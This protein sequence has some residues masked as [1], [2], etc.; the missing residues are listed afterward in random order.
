M[1]FN[2]LRGDHKLQ[3]HEKYVVRKIF[4]LQLQSIS[5]IFDTSQNLMTCME[6]G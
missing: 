3:M 5:G 2:L 1:Y 6:P 4:G